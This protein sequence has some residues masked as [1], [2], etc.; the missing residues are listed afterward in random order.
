MKQTTLAHLLADS[1]SA[2]PAIIAEAPSVEISHRSLADQVESLAG[3]LQGAGLRAGDVVAIVLPNGAELLV[4]FLALARV[5]MIAAPFNPAY[6]ADELHGLLLDLEPRAIIAASGNN[7]VAA[8]A[9]KLG[10]PIWSASL[11]ASGTVT[12][13]G[14]PPTSR[15]ALGAPD[16]N[17]V[18]LLLH[19][20]GTEG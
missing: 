19:T 12:L 4:L 6:K 14:I 8:G 5:G 9:A 17:D 7:A 20:S 15:A 1:P 13:R 18:A 3:A 16:A 2:E 10:V 11:E